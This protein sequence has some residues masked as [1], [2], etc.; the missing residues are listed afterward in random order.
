[1]CLWKLHAFISKSVGGYFKTRSYIKEH[2]CSQPSLRSNY[3]KV[4]Y[5]VCNVILPMV[6]KKLDMT[7]SYI[8]EY[9]EVKYHIN[10]TYNKV[11]N[12][13]TKARTKI[14]GD[15]ESSYEILLQYLNATKI[16]NSGIVAA[17]YF[18]P[19]AYSMVQFLR[20]CWAFGPP[21]KIFNIND[22][23]LYGKYKDCCL[24]F[25]SRCGWWTVPIG[26]YSYRRE[27]ISILKMVHIMYLSFNLQCVLEQENYFFFDWMK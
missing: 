10:I 6:R 8:I 15:W 7:L 9:I 12:A 21:L 19:Y 4:T 24:L 13:R 27:N 22:T 25:E 20:I 11:W 2:T 14:F 17:H 23:H 1:M 16:S 18:E 26:L 5:F 3:C